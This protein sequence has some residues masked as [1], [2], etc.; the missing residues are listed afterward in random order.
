M[1]EIVGMLIAG[2]VAETGDVPV[3]LRTADGQLDARDPTDDAVD[4]VVRHDGIGMMST[5]PSVSMPPS[6][7]DVAVRRG[8]VDDRHESLTEDPATDAAVVAVAG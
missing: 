3:D 7:I 4:A 8:G 6:S 2:A 1:I 5:A